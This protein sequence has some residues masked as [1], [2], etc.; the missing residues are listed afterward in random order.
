MCIIPL[1]GKFHRCFF[2]FCLLLA[3][4]TVLQ[5]EIAIA[6]TVLEFRVCFVLSLQVNWFRSFPCDD[7]LFKLG[8]LN[9]S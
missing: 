9:M 7:T 8:G 1:K 5:L 2:A 3:W 6:L 4:P